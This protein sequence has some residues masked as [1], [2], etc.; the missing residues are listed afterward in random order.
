M[1]RVGNGVPGRKCWLNSGDEIHLA[2]SG[3]KIVFDLAEP[4]SDHLVEAAEAGLESVGTGFQPRL[5][6]EPAVTPG[7]I[8]TIGASTEAPPT[9]PTPK[10]P[11]PLPQEAAETEVRPRAGPPPL[12]QPEDR[13]SSLSRIATTRPMAATGVSPSVATPHRHEET[14]FY[15]YLTAYYSAT[16]GL[17]IWALAMVLGLLLVP[18]LSFMKPVL[19]FEGI[20]RIW[21]GLAGL[22]G[23]ATLIFVVRRMLGYYLGHERAVPED[24]ASWSSLIAYGGWTMLIPLCLLVAV[25]YFSPQ[26]GV[27]TT[28]VPTLKEQQGR[29]LASLEAAWRRT[30]FPADDGE[31]ETAN[32]PTSRDEESTVAS[33]ERQATH[34]KSDLPEA[35]FTAS[36]FREYPESVKSTK[37]IGK[38]ITVTGSC[39]SYF[40]SIALV[41]EVF[42]F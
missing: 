18:A 13:P 42:G 11:P 25:E 41:L 6:P 7:S 40:Y 31:G 35:D 36:F 21:F 10:R 27:L 33:K 8:G 38:R 3:T 19:G 29:W 22:A 17:G 37:Y 28:L 12:P 30:G 4:G 24:A 32:P 20:A 2:E 23:G 9:P 1:I 34:G 16:H 5:A 26:H 39:S 15:R 14:G